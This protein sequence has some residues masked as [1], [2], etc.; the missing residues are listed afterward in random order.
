[1]RLS[2][3]FLLSISRV[4]RKKSVRWS[5]RRVLGRREKGLKEKEEGKVEGKISD[6]RCIRNPQNYGRED[7][8]EEECAAS[9]APCRSLRESSM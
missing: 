9:W 1:M 4:E 3:Q 5:Y 7:L 8:Y 2:T 6:L